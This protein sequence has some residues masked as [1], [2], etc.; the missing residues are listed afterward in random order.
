M[1]VPFVRKPNA[2]VDQNQCTERCSSYHH[3][4]VPRIFDSKMNDQTENKVYKFREKFCLCGE[5]ND[6]GKFPETQ[7]IVKQGFQLCTGLK[8]KRRCGMDE[9]IF[10]YLAFWNKINNA[11]VYF[12]L[13]ANPNL[14]VDA[15][16][17]ERLVDV[18]NYVIM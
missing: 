12:R 2:D 17:K 11:N 3:D 1:K 8:C 5:W 13:S 16:V 18:H 10:I 7:A 15:C 6:L 9:V 4:Y 14:D